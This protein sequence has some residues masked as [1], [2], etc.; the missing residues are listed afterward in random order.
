MLLT[1]T[2]NEYLSGAHDSQ[3][4]VSRSSNASYSRKRSEESSTSDK[5]QKISNDSS[6]RKNPISEIRKTLAKRKASAESTEEAKASPRLDWSEP[7]ILV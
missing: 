5:V 2:I 1:G 7:P 6:S 4:G 3:Q